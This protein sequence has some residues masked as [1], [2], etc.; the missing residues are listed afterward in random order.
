MVIFRRV[1]AGVA[2]G[3]RCGAGYMDGVYAVGV[4]EPVVRVQPA[5]EA[6]AP[7]RRHRADNNNQCCGKNQQPDHHRQDADHL[8]GG[9]A[10]VVVIRRR[11]LGVG[12]KGLGRRHRHGH[13]DVGALAVAHG[14]KIPNQVA[15]FL[16]GVVGHKAVA[17]APAHLHVL[18]HQVVKPAGRELKCRCTV[19][20][21][22]KQVALMHREREPHPAFAAV[23]GG[24][25]GRVI[26]PCKHN[27]GVAAAVAGVL[28]IG[29]GVGQRG[30]V[31]GVGVGQTDLDPGEVVGLVAVDDLPGDVVDNVR[32]AILP[33]V[34]RDEVVGNIIQ[35]PIVRIRRQPVQIRLPA[36]RPGRQRE[37][38]GR[39]NKNQ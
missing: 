19:T 16:A 38:Q 28:Q 37:Q 17:A 5:A 2:L 27:F 39:C 18:H 10:A 12:V 25:L 3:G 9:H 26:P 14:A 1:G 4:P 7:V 30:Q 13:V 6:A 11:Q 8:V 34:H 36:L 32:R 15:V 35:I 23:L 20:I 24:H 29:D 33:Q 21:Q 22:G 31:L